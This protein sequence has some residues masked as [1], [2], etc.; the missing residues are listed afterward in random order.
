[1]LH[2]ILTNKTTNNK[3]TL[4]FIIYESYDMVRY[5]GFDS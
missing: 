1:M 4:R 5:L 3:T 2:L